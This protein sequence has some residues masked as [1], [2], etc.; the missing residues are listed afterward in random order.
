[1]KIIKNILVIAIITLSPLLLNAQPKPPGPNGNPYTHGDGG[2][3]PVGGGAPIDG[4]LSI[5]LAM[6][7]IYGSKKVY[8]IKKAN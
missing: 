2:N 7:L 3:Q 4:G 1:M 6:G 5:L 8:Q